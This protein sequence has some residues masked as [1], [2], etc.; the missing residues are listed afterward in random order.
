MGATIVVLAAFASAAIISLMSIESPTYWFPAFVSIAG[1]LAGGYTLVGDTRR[2]RKG[3]LITD[4]EIIDVGAQIGD[5]GD[6]DGNPEDTASVRR[7]AIA[8]MIWLVA[9]PTLALVVPFFH[10][11]LLWLVA[12][13]KFQAKKSWKF[14]IISVVVFGVFLNVMVVLLD[15][16]LPPSLFGLG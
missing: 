13:L 14:T 6:G 3:L 7:R 8:W 5:H 10:A 16:K 9:L 15:V 11:V 2:L 1:C 4:V 12:V